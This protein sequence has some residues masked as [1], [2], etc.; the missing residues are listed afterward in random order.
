M[1][2]LINKHIFCQLSYSY[3]FW[4]IADVRIQHFGN[5]AQNV[6]SVETEK[7]VADE[8]ITDTHKLNEKG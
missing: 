2:Y 5:M 4:Y 3:V 8:R 6:N 1:K 7:R